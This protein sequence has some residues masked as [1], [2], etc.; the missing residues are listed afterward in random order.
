MSFCDAGFF[1]TP[2]KEFKSFQL[3]IWIS[4]NGEA[5]AVSLVST[6]QWRQKAD[7]HEHICF[8]HGDPIEA[9]FVNKSLHGSAGSAMGSPSAWFMSVRFCLQEQ[10]CTRKSCLNE[11]EKLMR[12]HL[13]LPVPTLCASRCSGPDSDG[14]TEVRLRPFPASYTAP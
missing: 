8:S 6:A 5:Q 10:L 4:S 1:S 9:I 12:L 14:G 7:D 2:K 13:P 3:Y 11:G